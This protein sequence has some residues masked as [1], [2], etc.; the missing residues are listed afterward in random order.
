MMPSLPT[1]PLEVIQPQLLFHLL[2]I[3]LY[4]P[5]PSGYI[6]QPLQTYNLWQITQVILNRSL[7]L[8]QATRS[9]T[10]WPC[11]VLLLPHTHA[12]SAPS[13][14]R[15]CCS[16]SLCCPLAKSQPETSA[17]EKLQLL[18]RL[19]A[20]ASDNH[21]VAAADALLAAADARLLLAALAILGP[22]LLYP[23]HIANHA[24]LIPGENQ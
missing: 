3:L 23:P 21:T 11:P 22:G 4:S 17:R 15:T 7:L 20:F 14:S 2:I 6:Y 10:I 13:A 12:P 5:S 19:S 9:T 1:P 24:F 8:L 18:A 16:S